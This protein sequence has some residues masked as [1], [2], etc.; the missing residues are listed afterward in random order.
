MR[1]GIDLGGTKI[2]AVVLNP[3]GVVV[4]RL[5]VPTPKGDYFKTVET[6]VKLVHDLETYSGVAC[7][8]GIGMPG[9]ISPKTQRVKNANSIWLNH[10]DFKRDLSEALKRELRVANDANCFAVSEAVDGAGKGARFVMAI[11][12]GTGCG[13]FFGRPKPSK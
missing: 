2:E 6:I 5:R 3:R 13:P 9:T 7:T 8:V 10:R 4:H 1:I 11:I 12:L